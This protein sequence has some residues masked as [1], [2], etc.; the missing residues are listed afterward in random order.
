MAKVTQGQSLIATLPKQV[1]FRGIVKMRC[2]MLSG[3][4][5]DGLRN[6]SRLRIRDA[7]CGEGENVIDGMAIDG[8]PISILSGFEDATIACNGFRN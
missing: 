6:I 2:Q 1:N 3:L 5:G 8:S 4:F 7:Y